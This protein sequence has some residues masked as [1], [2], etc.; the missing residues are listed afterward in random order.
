MRNFGNVLAKIVALTVW[1][2]T[3]QADDLC[4]FSTL[5]SE[6]NGTFIIYQTIHTQSVRKTSVPVRITKWDS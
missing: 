2:G 5:F 4:A 3:E 6:K 1:G